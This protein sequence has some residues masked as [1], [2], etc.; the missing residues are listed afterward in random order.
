M[1]QPHQ[2]S[3]QVATAS[4]PNDCSQTEATLAALRR[5]GMARRW[6]RTAG[7]GMPE[8]WRRS[9]GSTSGSSAGSGT[10]VS[11]A[12]RGALTSIVLTGKILHLLIT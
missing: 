12:W 8:A 6:S 11:A 3:S 7:L 4:T 5:S 9:V 2:R 1:T 10:M